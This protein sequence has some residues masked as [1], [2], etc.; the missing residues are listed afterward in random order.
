MLMH[1]KDEVFQWIED[2][3]EPESEETEEEKP[4][5]RSPT[6]AAPKAT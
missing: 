4:V 5:R 6:K 1:H 2:R 3:I